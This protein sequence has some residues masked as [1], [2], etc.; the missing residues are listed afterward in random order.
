MSRRLAPS[1]PVH[2]GTSADLLKLR[3]VPSRPFDRLNSLRLG[4]PP[5]QRFPL[6]V[7]SFVAIAGP[8]N[9]RLS[10]VAFGPLPRVSYPPSGNPLQPSTTPPANTHEPEAGADQPRRSHAA[11]HH[12]DDTPQATFPCR[13]RLCPRTPC[14]LPRSP[15]LP[16]GPPSRTAFAEVGLTALN[17]PLGP[18][19][20]V[21]VAGF[22][23]TQI[24]LNRIDVT[25]AARPRS[26]STPSSWSRSLFPPRAS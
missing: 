9:T 5:A 14:R 13:I 6:G 23:Q 1:Y 10:C 20:T 15:A 4:S 2:P 7:R 19:A 22:R 16:L 8:F 12:G 17:R 24:T 25:P 21:E 26:V 3:I 11:L 18:A